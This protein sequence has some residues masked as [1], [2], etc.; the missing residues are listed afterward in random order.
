MGLARARR[1]PRRPPIITGIVIGAKIRSLLSSIGPSTYDEV[2]PKIEYWIEYAL[3]D[4][5]MTVEDLVE[6]LSSVAWDH[7]S[8]VIAQFLKEFRGA[9]HRSEPARSFV[10]ALCS[11]VLRWF[12]A[13][14]AGDIPFHTVT[15]PAVETG[16]ATSFRKAASF[17]GHLIEYGLLSHQLVRRHLVKPL[18]SHHSADRNTG[19]NYVRANAIHQLFVAAGNTLLHGLLEPED[20]QVCFEILDIHI[21]LKTIVLLNQGKLQVRWVARFGASHRDLTRLASN[22][23][24][25]TLHG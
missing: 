13:A 8:S 23:A 7:H 24:S 16:G 20:V 1:V 14:S 9:P 19:G 3:T 15:P 22:F 6:K 11:R 17:V 21:A 4:Q 10:D 18:I 12:S 5:S 25:P 2:S